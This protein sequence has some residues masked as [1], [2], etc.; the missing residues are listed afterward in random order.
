MSSS[1]ESRDD[2]DDG[3][4]TFQNS[5]SRIRSHA[6]LTRVARLGDTDAGSHAVAAFAILL[7]SRGSIRRRLQKQA[8]LQRETRVEGENKRRVEWRRSCCCR[9][10]FLRE[11]SSSRFRPQSERL[12]SIGS[13]RRR[14]QQ[15]L[16]RLSEAEADV[17]MMPRF[18]LPSKTGGDAGKRAA[19]GMRACEPRRHAIAFTPSIACHSRDERATLHQRR[20]MHLQNPIFSLLFSLSL[21]CQRKA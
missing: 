1:L 8:A 14:R 17:E 15:Q 11:K 4:L 7:P 20:G 18:H 16:T 13:S 12:C 10:A 6:T 9:L 3:R 19:G 2:D 5:R 21:V